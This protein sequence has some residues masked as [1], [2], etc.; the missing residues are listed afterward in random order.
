L[1]SIYE[2]KIHEIKRTNKLIHIVAIQNK[3]NMSLPWQKIQNI[4]VY[5]KY[6]EKKQ[7]IKI[8]IKEV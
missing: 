8:Q 2:T 1:T 3:T 7:G 5:K 4:K 6:K